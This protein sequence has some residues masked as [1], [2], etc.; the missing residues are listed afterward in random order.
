MW[1][2]RG[3]LCWFALHI[4]LHGN[5]KKKKTRNSK[6]KKKNRHTQYSLLPIG[7]NRKIENLF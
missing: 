7:Q 2:K 5:E 3:V 4:I 1:K 6:K